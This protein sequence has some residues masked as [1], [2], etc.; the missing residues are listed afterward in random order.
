MPHAAQAA[1]ELQHARAVA[2]ADVCED[3]VVPDQLELNA[4][5]LT[6]YMWLWFDTDARVHIVK[7]I[8]PTP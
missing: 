1:A 2:D 8:D 3:E 6:G 5:Q 7:I 4:I